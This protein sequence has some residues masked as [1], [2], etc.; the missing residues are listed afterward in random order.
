MKSINFS[1][2]ESDVKVKS[3]IGIVQ[4]FGWQDSKR[5]RK[6]TGNIS[7]INHLTS[8]FGLNPTTIFTWSPV[9]QYVGLHVRGRPPHD[10]RNPTKN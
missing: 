7:S 9:G 5:V 2:F 3:L 6:G 4:E 1:D 8:M 10:G